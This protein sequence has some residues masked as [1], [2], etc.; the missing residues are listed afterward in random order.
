MHRVKA[1]LIP[2]IAE[3]WGQ[4]NSYYKSPFGGR[5]N[6]WV[7][8]QQDL[9]YRLNPVRACDNH[10]K[11]TPY[12]SRLYFNQENITG[13]GGMFLPIA[14][15]ERLGLDKALDSVFEHNGYW[16]STSALLKSALVSI[17]AGA[18]RLYDVNTF[19]FDPGLTR[20]LGLD[21][22]PEEGNL[23]KRLDK[24]KKENMEAL[25]RVL[26]E[27]LAICNQTE[28][29][30][31][32]GL[33]F[34]LTTSVVYGKQEQSAVGY[35]PHKKGRPC[36]QIGLVFISNNGDLVRSEL[37]PGN[38]HSRTDFESFFKKTE[39]SLPP[40]YR[41]TFVRIDKGFFDQ[42][43]FAFLERQDIKYV[44]ASKATHNLL[45]IARSL[46]TYRKLPNTDRELFITEINYKYGSW[47]QSRRMVIVKERVPN[48]DY[49]P[50]ERDLFG[51]ASEPEFLEIFR[52]YVTNIGYEELD[53]ES[54]YH[55]YNERATA[56]NRIKESKM[57]FY[58]DKLPNQHFWGNALYLQLVSLAYNILNWFKRFILPPEFR[59]K[60]MRWLRMNLLV[61]PALIV[62]KK[63]QW[64]IKYSAYLPHRKLLLTIH[65]R[66]AEGK[67][68]YVV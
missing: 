26:R 5:E 43:L 30:V 68:Y 37:R 25:R 8:A 64:F 65:R 56:E 32:I 35:N 24:A 51:I 36:Y 17:F 21:Q 23:R 53:A 40:N 59:S 38:T 13:Y 22:L 31:E 55:F 14:F 3:K 52:F 2:R 33:D 48:P 41:I 28:D 54:V 7:H 66:L 57:G 67:P 61:L 63:Y 46:G 18:P 62:R 19:R 50:D 10:K 44:A 60:S 58:L 29:V 9:F 47:Q 11:T 39:A 42:K 16:Y 27:G 34:D 20:A 15:M 45:T 4:K 6:R 49:N 1:D 12:N